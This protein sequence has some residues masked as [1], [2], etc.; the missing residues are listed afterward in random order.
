[1]AASVPANPEPVPIRRPVASAVPWRLDHARR[2]DRRVFAASSLT[3]LGR[4]G[5]KLA[6]A[7]FLIVAARL[8][9]KAEYG[10]YSYV[11]VLAGTF[12][13]M[14]DP[15]VTVLAG[16]DVSSGTPRRGDGL[17]GGVSDRARH[18]GAG[19]RARCSRS[20]SWSPVPASA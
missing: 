2:S 5:S 8:L 11:L 16:R 17:L 12:A 10:V 18:R 13:I 3:I 7:L 9:T 6:V 19:G 14:A 20:G 15:Q 4:V 1:M